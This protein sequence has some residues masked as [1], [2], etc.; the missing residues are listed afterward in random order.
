[1]L[2]V[3]DN[4]DLVDMLALIVEFGARPASRRVSMP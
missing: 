1:V 2:V 4:V 3:D